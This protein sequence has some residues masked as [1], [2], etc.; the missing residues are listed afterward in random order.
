MVLFDLQQGKTSHHFHLGRKY[1]LKKIW[2]HFAMAWGQGQRV[3]LTLA[4][5]CLLSVQDCL[6][7]LPCTQNLQIR[8]QE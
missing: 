1:K 2:T 8:V 5:W 4:N 7:S 6:C 3:M